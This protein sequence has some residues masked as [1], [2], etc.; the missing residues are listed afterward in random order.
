MAVPRTHTL[1][2][3]CAQPLQTARDV[4]VASGE[5]SAWA[6]TAVLLLGLGPTP[7]PPLLSL[8]TI[9]GASRANLARL[10]LCCA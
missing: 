2:D 9:L 4:Q 7:G 6:W 3:T 10:D 1:S 8:D 5:A